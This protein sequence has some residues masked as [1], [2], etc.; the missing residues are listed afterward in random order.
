[1]NNVLNYDSYL[2]DYGPVNF[3]GAGTTFR[4]TKQNQKEI[5][6]A[7]GPLRKSLTLL[8]SAR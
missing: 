3:R 5:I 4:F 8:V 1:M 2:A 6:T 7:R